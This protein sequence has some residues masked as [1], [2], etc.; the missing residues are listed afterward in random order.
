MTPVPLRPITY[1]N[2]NRIRYIACNCKELKY[3]TKLKDI[4]E[5]KEK[6]EE[7]SGKEDT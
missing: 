6:I 2:Y 5:D 4:K 3:I 1:F 7:S